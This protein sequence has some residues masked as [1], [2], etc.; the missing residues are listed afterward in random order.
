[1][2]IVFWGTPDFAVPS[3][4]ALDEEG[5]DIVAVV[6]QP[7]RPAGRGRQLRPSPVKEVALEAGISVMTPMT[8][9]GEQFMAELTRL[10]PDLSVVVAYGQILRREVLDIP[11]RGSVN[12]HASL[13]PAHR[14]AAPINWAIANGDT[15]TGV[16]VMRMVE[17]LDAGPV[18]FTAEEPIGPHETASEL[19]ARLAE[20]GAAALVEALAL[21][22]AGVH[23]EVEQ[24]EAQSSYAPKVS[25]EV[26][27]MDWSKSAVDIGNHVRAMDSVPGAWTQLD[28]EPLKLFR[29]HLLDKGPAGEPGTVVIADPLDGLIVATVDG[30]IQF[31]EVQPPGKRRMDGTAWIVGRGV[32]QGKRFE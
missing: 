9:S 24:D 22:E 4:R 12:V 30:W 3:L 31:V 27:R 23:E 14:G 25:R 29:P 15:V 1:M 16:C 17:A 11:R 18:I 2:K 19:T 10:Q 32:S 21:M 7:D 28:G 8:P 5:H 26:A 6:T 13:L 20:V